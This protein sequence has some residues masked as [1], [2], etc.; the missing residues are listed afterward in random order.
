VSV[1]RSAPPVKVVVAGR[2]NVPLGLDVLGC[3]GP[4]LLRDPRLDRCLDDAVD[5][6]HTCR[7]VVPV[8]KGD[9]PRHSL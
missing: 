7:L 4:S 3:L 2:T 8:A 1:R 6:C 5:E 9:G